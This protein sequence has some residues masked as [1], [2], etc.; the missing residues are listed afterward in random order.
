M[1]PAETGCDF[2]HR[3]TEPVDDRAWLPKPSCS[4]C[5]LSAHTLRFF[6][7]LPILRQW[8]TLIGLVVSSGLAAAWPHGVSAG[9]LPSF[10]PF[11]WSQP[12]LGTLISIVMFFV[13]CLLP[14]DELRQVARRWPAV[15]QG[16]TLQYISMPLLAW[17]AATLFDLSPSTK[18]GVIMVGCVPGAMASNVLTLLARGNTSYSVCLTTTSTMLSP[19]AVPWLLWLMLS[20]HHRL[21]VWQVAWQ[22]L[23]QVVF[24]VVG[25]FVLCRLWRP[26]A[27]L[28][29]RLAPLVTNCAVLW[30]VA[31]V[32]ATNR[33]RLSDMTPM[34][35]V[36]LLGINV[37]GYVAGWFGGAVMRLDDAMRRALA[38]EIGM[39]NCALGTVLVLSLFPDHPTAAIP[40]AAYTFGC[41]FTGSLL[42]SWWSQR[43]LTS[44]DSPA[45]STSTVL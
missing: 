14:P 42:A 38:L 45:L 37:L 27:F 41:V 43:P 12:H 31:V 39:Q 35:A 7:S 20:T 10:D 28:A 4:T 40:T 23:L 3:F 36:I 32:V 25:G 21:D 2:A 11:L 9:L 19:I 17:L 34:L 26:M 44:S 30:V 5:I 29:D 13:G 22:L 16:T 18:I 8:G 33:H 24:P 6:E 1:T 15:V